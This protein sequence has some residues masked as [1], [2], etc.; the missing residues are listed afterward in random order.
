MRTLLASAALPGVVA[1][2]AKADHP[3]TEAQRAK[4]AAAVAA[5]GGTGGKATTKLR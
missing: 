5:Q 2:P 4:L 3:V 1:F